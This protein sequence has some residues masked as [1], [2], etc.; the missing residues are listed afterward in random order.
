MPKKFVSQWD[1]LTMSSNCAVSIWPRLFLYKWWEQM[2]EIKIN[3][4]FSLLGNTMYIIK[5]LT[6][7]TSGYRGLAHL[8]ECSGHIKNPGHIKRGW[9]LTRNQD[10]RSCSRI[11]DMALWDKPTRFI[12]SRGGISLLWN[13]ASNQPACHKSM[14]CGG[15]THYFKLLWPENKDEWMN[16]D[17]T[18]FRVHKQWGETMHYFKILW[19]RSHDLDNQR[20]WIL[21]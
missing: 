5:R 13:G 7:P 19:L 12:G 11:Q 17:L 4:F 18:L 14:A 16:F 8:A 6:V 1:I 3:D 20:E 15:T 10:L 9:C 21:I 2:A